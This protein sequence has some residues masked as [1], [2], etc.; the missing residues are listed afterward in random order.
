MTQQS[1]GTQPNQLH[2]H[3]GSQCGISGIDSG[4][5]ASQQAP[6]TQPY[7]GLQ[8]NPRP[9]GG[10]QYIQH[11][12][13]R[14]QTTHLQMMAAAAMPP[15]PP[16]LAPTWL[17]GGTKRPGLAGSSIAA[18]VIQNRPHSQGGKQDVADYGET[19]SLYMY[20]ITHAPLLCTTPPLN[21]ITS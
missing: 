14:A 19:A 9:A 11:A 20:P 17:S 10:I 8:E 2:Q 21:P 18:P 12:G 4:L 7:P 15:P 1:F 3:P 13:A 5:F 6:S 16:V